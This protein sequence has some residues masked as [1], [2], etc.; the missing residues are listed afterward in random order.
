RHVEGL[1]EALQVRF[2]GNRDDNL[3][4][5]LLSDFRDAVR[6]TIP[7]DEPLLSLAKARIEELNEKYAQG[8]DN[9]FFLFHR[10]RQW[11]TKERV[12]MGY[13]RKRGKLA[14]LNSLLRTSYNKTHR[15]T[16]VVAHRKI[17]S[18]VTYVIAFDTNT[19]LQ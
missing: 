19:A 10:P 15:F 13:E 12:W 6:E 5:A 9:T 4:V 16:V 14:D 3:H 1:G 11:N 17:L 18:R 8:K 7:E 2:F